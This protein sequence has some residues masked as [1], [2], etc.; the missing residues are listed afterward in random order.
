MF[1]GDELIILNIKLS[2][3]D[4]QFLTVLFSKAGQQSHFRGVIGHNQPGRSLK[5]R[6]GGGGGGSRTFP[7]KFYH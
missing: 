5:P 7:L 4:K 3:G 6:G 2:T 1:G